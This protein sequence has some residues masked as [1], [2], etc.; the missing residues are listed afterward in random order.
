[1]YIYIYT[2]ICIYADTH[3]AP[4]FIRDFGCKLTPSTHERSG[5]CSAL[6]RLADGDMDLFMG[7]GLSGGPKRRHKHMAVSGLYISF[8]QYYG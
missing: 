1:M 3:V 8:S 7:R 6:V 5:R 4:A 2:Y